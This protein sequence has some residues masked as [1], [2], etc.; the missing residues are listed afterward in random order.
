MVKPLEVK[1]GMKLEPFTYRVEQSKIKEFAVAI[2]DERPEYM[3]GEC[4]PPTFP[5]VIDFW[6]TGGTGLGILLGLNIA[7]VLHGEHEYQ[8]LGKIKLGDTITVYGEVDDVYIKA[9]MKFIVV[10]K[11][12]FNQNNELVLISRSTIIERQ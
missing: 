1:V 9:N 4:V 7:K 12:L 6:G 8:Y 5:T 11:E 3:S 10:K 2:G